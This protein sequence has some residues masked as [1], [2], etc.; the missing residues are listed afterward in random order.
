MIMQHA[1]FIPFLFALGACVGSFLNVVVWRLPRD[2]SLVSPPS[3]CPK[4]GTRLAW[5][6]NVPVL[7]W[8]LLAGKCRYCRET[9][10]PRY[11]IIEFITGA[12]FVLY[13]VL[14]FMIQQGPCPPL[15]G[16]RPLSI[17]QDW[18]IYA[19]YMFLLASLL[20]ASLID[21]ELFIIP[22]EIPWLVAAVAILVHAII[23]RPTVP[24]SL[25]VSPPSAALAAGG[26]LGLLLSIILLRKKI[27]PLSFADS[28][29]LLEHEREKLAEETARAAREGRDPPPSEPEMT[30]GQIRGEIRKEILFLLPPMLLA[31]LAVYLLTAV[32]PLSRAWE[33]LL[34]WDAISVSGL[35]GSILGALVGGFVVWITR[36][37]GTLGFG[38]EAMGMGDVHL[39]F[40]VG[41]VVGAGAATVAFFVAP[42]FGILIAIYMLLTGK[43]RELPYG[44]Y[45]S[46]ATAFVVIWYCDIAEVLRPGM[47]GLHLMLRRLLPGS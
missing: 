46:L 31:M 44:P 30:S 13:Y 24:G 21:A 43:R 32:G 28:A 7:G 45:L 2:E 15:M 35:F 34:G 3:R 4:C 19:L 36:I 6:D 42:F 22:I 11:P 16:S 25:I 18:P 29:P 12:I 38:R 37:L 23:G 17:Y 14:F 47:D 5:Y 10:S 27:L 40:G 41:A 9:I 39:M 26:A 20:A 1:I 8:I 33:R